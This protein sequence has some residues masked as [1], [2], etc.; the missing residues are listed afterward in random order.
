[1]SSLFQAG[2]YV[3][4]TRIHGSQWQDRRGTIVDTI[5]RGEKGQLQECAVSL[6]SEQRWFMAQHLVRALSPHLVRPF[7]NA[8]VDRWKLDPD[9][10]LSL[11]GDE[12]ELLQLLCECCDLTIPRAQ[13][14]IEA[15]YQDFNTRTL[16]PVAA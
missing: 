16:L 9:R 12:D 10:V 2:D 3:R 8:V 4:V 5:L 7:R 6:G 14:E 13:K 1:M 15:F 11:S